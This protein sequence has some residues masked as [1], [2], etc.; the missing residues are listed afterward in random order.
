MGT[1]GRVVDAVRL[2]IVVTITH[3]FSVLVL[4]VI[5][6]VLSQYSLSRDFYP[7][8]G[9]ASG[10]LIMFTGYLLLARTALSAGQAHSHSHDGHHD[11]HNHDHHSHHDHSHVPAGNSLGEILSLGIAGGLVPCPSAIVILLFA[12]AVN[13]IAT[14]LLLIV[15]F[16]L[17][18]AVVLIAIGIFMV[19]A[20]SRMEQV[21]KSVGWIRKLPI[22]TAGIIMVLGLGVALKALIDGGI[23]I[24]NL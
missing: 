20:S 18:L 14:G 24:I 6:L 1:R 3:I 5:A 9:L 8:L 13:R 23:L 4:G 11:D 10:V 22:F 17:G 19:K 7:W 2:G 12:I 15:S 16:S 21:G